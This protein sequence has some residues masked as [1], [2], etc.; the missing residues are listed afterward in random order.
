[1]LP[2][3]VFL[4]KYS[5]GLHGGKRLQLTGNQYEKSAAVVLKTCLVRKNKKEVVSNEITS[6]L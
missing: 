5:A 4:N 1:M 2:V 6:F 3:Q